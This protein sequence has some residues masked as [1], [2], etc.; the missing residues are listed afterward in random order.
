MFNM[1]PLGAIVLA[2]FDE[3]K[4]LFKSIIT[5]TQ[6]KLLYHKPML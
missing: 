3:H 6:K 5:P 2:D 1:G 4:L